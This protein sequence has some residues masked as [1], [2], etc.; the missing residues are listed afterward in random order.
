MRKTVVCDRASFIALYNGVLI[1]RDATGRCVVGDRLEC[2][3]AREVLEAGGIVQLTID[4]VVVSSIARRANG[5][6]T[7][8]KL[9]E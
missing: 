6:V 7:E 8:E 9:G 5:E 3:R 2:Y 4:G 1:S